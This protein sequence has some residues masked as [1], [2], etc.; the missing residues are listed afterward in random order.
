MN[1]V[2]VLAEDRTGN[3]WIGGMG[4][5]SRYDG[6]RFSAFTVSDG[7]PSAS[8]RALYF[9]SDNVL[10]IGTYDGGLGRFDGVHF[11]RITTRNG[12]FSN[13]VFQI[14]EDANGYLWM[15]SNQGIYRARKQD[16]NDFVAGR[17]SGIH[18]IAYGKREG[19]LN[20][21]CNGGHWPAGVRARDG[22][23]WFPTEN[24]VA[25]VDPLRVPVDTAPP[26]VNIESLSSDLAPIPLTS[27]VKLNPRQRSFEIQY[28]A[29]S[30]ISPERIRFRYKLAGVDSDWANAG[31]RRAAYYSHVPHGKYQFQVIAANRDGVWNFQGRSLEVEVLPYFYETWWFYTMVAFSAVGTLYIGWRRH[32]ARLKEAFVSQQR[33]THQLIARQESE[34]ER[35]AAELHDS[36]GQRLAIIKNMAT[37][38]SFNQQTPAD[39]PAQLREISS[40]SSQAIREIREIAYNLRP[41]QLDQLGLTK[42]IE[43][44]LRKASQASG[45]VFSAALD[46][47][48]GCFPAESE[49]SF[50]RIVQEQ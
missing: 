32:T 21:E 2:T 4:G 25:V 1:F 5:L 10:W 49:I 41:Y 34:R 31:A 13:G 42:A 30:F 14:L 8:V 23:L 29:L 26:S 22:K 27:A 37:M 28:T 45:I 11:A 43:A 19:M 18:S 7:L 16:L 44:M 3:L 40:E 17:L 15:S 24:G 36:I 48:D 39:G 50:Y 12:L 9:D 35:I 46:P 38:F 33:F 6:H 47:L 20:E